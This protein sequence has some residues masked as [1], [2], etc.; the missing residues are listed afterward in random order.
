MVGASMTDIRIYVFSFNRGVFLENC[1]RS[2]EICAPSCE[3]LVVDDQS[4]DQKTKDILKYFSDK[5]QILI[6][7][8]HAEVEHKTGGLNN[9]MSFAFSDAR[10]KGFRY[11]LFLQDDMQLV[12]PLIDDDIVNAEKFFIAN[13]NSAELHT[14]FISS[15]EFRESD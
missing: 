15:D 7:G 3:V 14:C 1:L 8:E 2:I 13:E 11:V 4:N 10:E 5:F 6:V 9:N 12:R